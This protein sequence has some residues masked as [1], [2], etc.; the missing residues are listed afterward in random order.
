MTNPQRVRVRFAK[1]ADLRLIS[2]RDLV[3]LFERM[4]RRVGVTLAMSQGFHPRPLMTFPDALSLG[5]AASNEAMDISF[6]EEIDPDDLLQRMS[7]QAPDGLVIKTV[8]ILGDG[9]RKAK[10]ERVVYELNLPPETNLEE[11]DEAI[12]GLKKQE[13]LKVARKEKQVELN[14]TDSLEGL[15][16]EDARLMMNIRLTSQ[17]QLQPRDILAAIGLSEVLREGA[18]LTRTQ[19]EL[20]K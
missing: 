11:L 9:E 16:I 20:S 19:V 2:H 17:S 3:R 6:A 7:D 10:I 1:E 18:T 5:I 12:E 14:L 13:T 4:F 15:W 8:R